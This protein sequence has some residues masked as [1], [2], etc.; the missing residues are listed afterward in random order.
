[1]LCRAHGFV[2]QHGSTAVMAVVDR[3]IAVRTADTRVLVAPLGRIHSPLRSRTHLN[4]T[5]GPCAPTIGPNSAASMSCGSTN[6][7][8]HRRAITNGRSSFP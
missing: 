7:P 3:P 5:F 1:M 8:A 2:H 6:V 4:A